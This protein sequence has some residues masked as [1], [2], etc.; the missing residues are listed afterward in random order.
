MEKKEKEYG[1]FVSFYFEEMNGGQRV[2]KHT[3]YIK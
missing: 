3:F 2:G 1:Y